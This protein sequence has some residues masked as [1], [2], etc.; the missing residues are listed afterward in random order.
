MAVGWLQI[1]GKWYYFEGGGAMVTGWKQINSKWY[2]FKS[3]GAMSANEYYNGYWLNAD[4]TWTYKA[5]ASWRKNANGWWFGDDT[6]WYAKNRT[7]KINDKNYNFN[8]A[9][10]CTNP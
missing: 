4:G 9:G 6:G 2:L 7:L 3:G 8:A 5:R 10:Y 1:S